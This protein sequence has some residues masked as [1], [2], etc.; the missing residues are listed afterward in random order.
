MTNLT[1]SPA[2]CDFIRGLGVGGAVF[3]DGL[4]SILTKMVSSLCFGWIKIHPYKM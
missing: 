4:K 1:N 3:S 2:F